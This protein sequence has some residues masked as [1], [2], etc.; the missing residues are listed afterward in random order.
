MDDA[1]RDLEDHPLALLAHELRT[2]LTAVI[3]YADAMRLQAFGPLGA[4]YDHQA[5]V[6]HAAAL[7]LLALVDQ[8]SDTAAA[9]AGLW[10][11]R[12]ERFDLR[13]LS[14]D[15][16]E[17]LRPRATVAGITVRSRFEAGVGDIVAD[18]RAIGQILVNLLDNALKFTAAGGAIELA[19]RH[20][21]PRMR[22]VITDSGRPPAS[23]AAADPPHGQGL[24]LR[25]VRALCA[26]HGGSLAL[27]R[28]PA[29][30]MTATVLLAAPES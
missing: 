11:G 18:R 17:L 22:L 28:S 6:I 5:G 30:G 25:L 16:L 4:P 21:G 27:E 23:G 10:T 24:G 12:P 3:G 20:E 13:A 15:V 7:L 2:P 9:E 19:I 26:A 29:G 1:R 8:M 14:E